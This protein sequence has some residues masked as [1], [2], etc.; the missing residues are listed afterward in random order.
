MS[1]IKLNDIGMDPQKHLG[2]RIEIGFLN[3]VGDLDLGLN[4]SLHLF[5]K[6]GRFHLVWWLTPF[7]R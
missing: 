6:P 7:A 4:I 2:N 5:D 3:H 1:Q